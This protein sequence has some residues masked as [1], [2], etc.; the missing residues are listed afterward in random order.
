MLEDFKESGVNVCAVQAD[1]F[2]TPKARL[3]DA[4]ALLNWQTGIGSW[5]VCEAK[6][7]PTR[8]NFK[9]ALHAGRGKD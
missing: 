9:A 2:A 4:E 1:A 5:H 8:V 6:S 7:Y 3:Q